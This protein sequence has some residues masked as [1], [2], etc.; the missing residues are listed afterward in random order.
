MDRYS[1]VIPQRRRGPGRR[2]RLRVASA[3]AATTWWWLSLGAL[4]L[5]SILLPALV[6]AQGLRS[7]VAAVSIIAVKHPEPGE[8]RPGETLRARDLVLPAVSV[9]REDVVTVRLSADNLAPLYVRAL[10]GRLERV[11]VTP[12][13]VVPG[14]LHFRTLAGGAVS[15][16]SRWLVQVTIA[17]RSGPA[18][19]RVL[20][21][22]A[23]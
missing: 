7:S 19:E 3:P 4:T 8:A 13:S 20:E 9:Q 1:V 15:T 16:P 2:G 6:R 18:R 22:V 17:P 11:G 12:V 10:S 14:P 5:A 21:V 23:R